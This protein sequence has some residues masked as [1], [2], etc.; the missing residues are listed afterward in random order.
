MRKGMTLVVIAWV[1]VIIVAFLIHDATAQPRGFTFKPS[2]YVQ[3]TLTNVQLDTVFVLFPT[4]ADDWYIST[5]APTQYRVGTTL[6]SKESRCSGDVD[7]F[8]EVNT[9][10]GSTDSLQH[11]IK[12]L[13]WDLADGAID[14]IVSDSMFIW[15]GT[16]EVYTNTSVENLDW[17]SGQEYHCLLTSLLWPVAGFAVLV[18]QQAAGGA[19]CTATYQLSGS[20]EW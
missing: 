6:R 2:G 10:S 12:P 1:V 9:T 17:T 7:L 18:K 13:V 11:W 15:F 3:V 19:V 8:M 5:T 20:R 16:P 4:D 14:L